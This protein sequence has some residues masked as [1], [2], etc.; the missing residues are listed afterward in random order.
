MTLI[1]CALTGKDI[2]QVVDKA[3]GLDCD[4]VEVRLDLI[5]NV[6]GIKALEK[7]NQPVMSTCMP[8]DEGGEFEGSEVERLD[9][10]KKTLP[11]SNYISV[12]LRM[13]ADL[14]DE[15]VLAA[16]D[17]GVNVVMT[18]HDFEKTPTVDEIVEKLQAMEDVG[19]DIAKVAFICENIEDA[20]DIMA[21]KIRSKLEIPV[22]ALGMG[23]EGKITRASAPFIDCYLSFASVA[24]EEAT[25]PG[26][27]SL[28]ELKAIY[29]CIG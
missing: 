12:E 1:C 14:R 29:E 2:N 3:T 22:I 5:D 15:L 4:V 10:L 6:D 20:L 28:Q 11:Y 8:K 25:A 27:Y 17:A 19:A 23:E 24:E 26:Q 16:R 18:L 13:E 7:I 21:A 9:L